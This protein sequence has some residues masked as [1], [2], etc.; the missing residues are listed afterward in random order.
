MQ[1]TD[2]RSLRQ[3]RE[4]YRQALREKEARE[5]REREAAERARAERR[6]A[7]REARQ[8]VEA[9]REAA[10]KAERE[11]EARRKAEA[12]KRAAARA[13]AE[14]EAQEKERALKEVEARAR[15]RREESARRRQ[16]EAERRARQAE[17]W[18]IAIK[19][20]IQDRW[21]QP[22]A[23]RI[24]PCEAQVEQNEKG[25][26]LSVQ[27][28]RCRA[29]RAWQESLRS[30]V[31]RASPLPLPPAPELFDRQLVITFRPESA[32]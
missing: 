2:E 26:V 29:S 4:A 6:R 14:R 13:K 1:A 24:E 19:Q 8:K 20:R 31:R 17:A 23:G 10:K 5:R 9:E 27:V 32:R 7:E 28:R 16:R 15:T 25:E 30:A 12:K 11:R 18:R 21:L 22:P 3:K